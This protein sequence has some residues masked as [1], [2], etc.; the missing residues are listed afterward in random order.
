MSKKQM[1][2][3]KG[4]YRNSCATNDRAHKISTE[5]QRACFGYVSRH[6][7][8]AT[9]RINI[10]K[11]TVSQSGLKNKETNKGLFDNTTL[12]PLKK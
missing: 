7:R 11:P 3:K 12:N 4:H 10:Y 8:Q 1:E 6:R 5:S 2:S 9:L